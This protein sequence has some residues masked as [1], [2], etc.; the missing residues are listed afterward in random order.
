MQKAW[1]N[2]KYKK[3]RQS[4]ITREYGNVTLKLTW[5][6]AHIINLAAPERHTKKMGNC[7]TDNMEI[8]DR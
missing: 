3:T 8:T 5:P 1:I 7:A 4:Q 6:E 2:F